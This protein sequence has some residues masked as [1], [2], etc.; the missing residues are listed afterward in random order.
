[1]RTMITSPARA[2]SATVATFSPAP[3]ASA[4]RALP[5]R[6]PTTTATT[7]FHQVEG[8]GVSLAAVA[9]DGDRPVA[10]QLEIGVVVVVH[11]HRDAPCPGER[12]GGHGRRCG[13]HR[14]EH[15]SVTARE[16]RFRGSVRR[17][18]LKCVRRG[19]GGAYSIGPVRTRPGIRRRSRMGGRERRGRPN[20]MIEKGRGLTA[21]GAILMGRPESRCLVEELYKARN[22]RWNP[23]GCQEIGT[24]PAGCVTRRRALAARCPE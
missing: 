13:G 2:A 3:S 15:N 19:S 4:R 23:G 18:R 22:Y 12:G 20:R 6:R 1:M 8:M 21:L 5:S 9:D 17:L 7:A 16:S 10:Q 11:L 24:R 14:S